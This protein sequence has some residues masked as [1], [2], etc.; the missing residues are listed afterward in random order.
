MKIRFLFLLLLLSVFTIPLFS[1]EKLIFINERTEKGLRI[2]NYLYF[3]SEQHQ[4][5]MNKDNSNK[6]LPKEQIYISS[7]GVKLFSMDFGK[8]WQEQ[9]ETVNQLDN[10]KFVIY[11]NPASSSL[12]FEINYLGNE[13]LTTLRI[14]DVKGSKVYDTSINLKNISS[15]DIS[16]F[17]KGLYFIKVQSLDKIYIFIKE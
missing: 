16:N 13:Y 10:H 8:T 5:L 11:P 17:T 15:I 14:Y 1:K 4:E 6:V 9:I 2:E 3:N 7:K 12:N